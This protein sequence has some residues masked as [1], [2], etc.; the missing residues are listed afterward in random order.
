ML[1]IILGLLLSFNSYAL[2]SSSISVNTCNTR[3]EYPNEFNDHIKDYIDLKFQDKDFYRTDDEN[4]LLTK[5]N[6]KETYK[7]K[8]YKE[9]FEYKNVVFI[10]DIKALKKRL[11]AKGHKLKISRI[12]HVNHRY[13]YRNVIISGYKDSRK[14][15]HVECKLVTTIYSNSNYVIYKK[16]K[17]FKRQRQSSCKDKDKIVKNVKVPKCKV[18]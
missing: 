8:D 9:Y 17:V 5:I 10:S 2:F 15:D 1:K 11:K 16:E 12:R 7:Y 6:F 14:L 13:G 3:V 18:D 4:S